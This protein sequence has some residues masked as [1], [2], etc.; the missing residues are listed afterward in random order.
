LKPIWGRYG[1]LLVFAVTLAAYGNSLEGGYHY[2]DEH[3]LLNNANIRSLDNIPAFF[4]PQGARYFSVDADKGMYRPLLLSSYALNF[5]LHGFEVGGYHWGNILLHAANAAWVWWL[6]RLLGAAY[7]QALLAGLLFAIHPLAGEPVNYLSSRSESLVACGFLAA[8]ALFLRSGG[9]NN[10]FLGFSYFA[11][12]LALLSKSTAVV[13][14]AVVL[15]YDLLHRGTVDWRRLVARHVPFAALAVLYVGWISYIRFLPRS[16][17][18]QVRSATAQL[19]TQL[20]AFAYYLYLIVSPV[21]LNI[22]HQFLRQDQAEFWLTLLPAL[23]L[24][25]WL[26]V[27]GFLWKK[28]RFTPLWLNI[29]AAATLA[30]V[31]VVPLNIFVN[32]RRLYLALAA[33]CVGLGLLHLPRLE[34]RRTGRWV[35]AAALILAAFLSVGRN[36]VWADGFSL[37][38]DSVTKAPRMPRPHLYLGNTHVN[39]AQTAADTATA[40]FHWKEALRSYR[41]VIRWD[42]KRDLAVRAINNVGS[43]HF[44]LGYYDIADKAFRQALAENPSYAD[45][46]VGVGNVY[47]VR[48]RQSAQA[49]TSRQFMLE[50]ADQYEKAIGISPNHYQAHCNLGLMYAGLNEYDKARRAYER[51]LFLNPNDGLVLSNLA[52]LYK[53]LGF[54]EVRAGKEGRSLWQKAAGLY[55]RSLQASSV[56]NH[57]IGLARQG[58]AEVKRLLEKGR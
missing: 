36:G 32:E 51:A 35:G 3:S 23:L 44:V 22:E 27:L 2:D 26:G 39:A 10:R 55:Q 24:L 4:G 52:S 28:G 46:L 13:L 7:G 53:E 9:N 40:N 43:I 50:A 30:P 49:Q 57:S 1:W 6:A 42:Q 29:W 20:K 37:W 33:L 15:A 11:F 31:M 56:T 34:L 14:P 12:A 18:Q 25:S 48:A 16:L 58:L 5:A 38:Q 21:K 8:L 45:A 19:L 54:V 41:E 17:D 47:Q